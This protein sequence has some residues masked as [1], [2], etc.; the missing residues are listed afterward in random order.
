MIS[1]EIGRE[2]LLDIL[3]KKY[4]NI[5]DLR[6]IQYFFYYIKITQQLYSE[7]GILKYKT[8]HLSKKDLLSIIK[9]NIE[10]PEGKV[11]VDW[12]ANHYNEVTK[13][14]VE[15]KKRKFCLLI[16]KK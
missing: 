11:R 8:T 12:Y 3:K 10:L 9:E 6:S 16:S 1:F 7:S 14:I 13:V 15:I 5:V 4:P 2:K